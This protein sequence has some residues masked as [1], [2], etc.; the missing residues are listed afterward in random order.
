M[1]GLQIVGVLGVAAAL[2]AVA[3]GAVAV[4]GSGAD[5]TDADSAIIERLD[6][7]QGRVN[8]LRDG[9]AESRDAVA[10]VR[11]RVVAVELELSHRAAPTAGA[12]ARGE[13]P[14]ATIPLGT[15]SEER[16]A[17]DTARA[18]R[19]ALGQFKNQRWA[20][21]Q[22]HFADA[23]KLRAMPEDERWG[24]A[25][26]DLGLTT[27]QVDELRDAHADFEEARTAA[28]SEEEVTV[29]EGIRTRV[30]RADSKKL[31]AAKA[32]LERRVDNTLNSEQKKAW[33]DKGYST[34]FGGGPRMFFAR[35]ALGISTEVE[36]EAGEKASDE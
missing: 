1:T 24:K 8:G 33:S 14:N 19:K 18:V 32:E 35:G 22:K 27:V 21:V 5:T 4:L 9:V 10:D 25:E 30:R 31:A 6:D 34:A 2:G 7:L 29:G 28:I 20:D 23:M 11:E 12:V 3:G 16:V 17:T 26:E 15:L 13:D 36:V